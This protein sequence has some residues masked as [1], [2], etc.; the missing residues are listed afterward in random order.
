MHDCMI[1]CMC[2]GYFTFRNIASATSTAVYV[3]TGVMLVFLC[4]S[5]RMIQDTY[6]VKDIPQSYHCLTSK[7]KCFSLFEDS[8][9]TVTI[10][11]P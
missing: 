9:I 1:S 4:V 5:K 8:F 11:I 6:S 2:A 3:L 7:T 10:W